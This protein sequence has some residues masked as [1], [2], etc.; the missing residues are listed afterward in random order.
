MIVLNDIIQDIHK[1]FSN[2]K[3]CFDR[4]DVPLG[5][6]LPEAWGRFGL[7]LNET[8]TYPLGWKSFANEFPS[9]VALLDEGLL[10]TALLVDDVM[11]LLYV[12]HD[13]NGFYYYV[14]GLPVGRSV[15]EKEEFK[16]L[17]DKLR[18]FYQLVHDGFTFFPARSM[19]PQRL[20]DFSRVSDL[21]DEE[22]VSFAE[23]WITI[24][25]NGGG[26]FVAIDSNATHG[27]E[28]LIWWHEDP[29][30]PENEVN[31]F[32]V[33]DAWMAIFLEDTKPREEL[34]ARLH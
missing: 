14:G 23:S 29:M 28:G 18:K 12:F 25:S 13:A 11:E 5:V 22:D 6:D 20:S 24:F 33:M 10:G 17:P 34:I 7:C 9:V 32:E 31:I 19:G 2:R 8:P 1:N 30:A 16:S 26:D 15:E 27:S 4:K 3:I 21:I